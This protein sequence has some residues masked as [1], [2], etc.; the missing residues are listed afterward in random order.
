MTFVRVQYMTTGTEPQSIVGLP[1]LAGL[2]QVPIVSG[3]GKLRKRPDEGSCRDVGR[4]AEHVA[5]KA[6][7][8]NRWKEDGGDQL[9]AGA[10]I[11]TAV[12]IRMRSWD[13]LV[14]FGLSYDGRCSLSCDPYSLS[15][16]TSRLG[17]S[18]RGASARP[19]YP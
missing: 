17:V 19:V 4:G 6:V 14:S 2:P 7:G 5:R 13:I 15:S 1:A 9:L 18:A 16:S 8:G 11:R 10:G 3:L 12:G